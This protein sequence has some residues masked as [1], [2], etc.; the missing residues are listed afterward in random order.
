MCISPRSRSASRQLGHRQRIGLYASQQRRADPSK[1][2]S[3]ASSWRFMGVGFGEAPAGS[4]AWPIYGTQR[5]PLF[6]ITAI[7]GVPADPSQGWIMASD[8]ITLGLTAANTASFNPA[9]FEQLKSSPLG[10]NRGSAAVVAR[11]TVA[12]QA[13]PSPPPGPFSGT[14][15]VDSGVSYAMMAL[16]SGATRPPTIS[17][18]YR[19]Q[20]CT[21]P[22]Y[23][24]MVYL[25]NPNLPLIDQVS[26]GANG[27][28]SASPF[29]AAAPA[30]VNQQHDMA[31]F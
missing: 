7:N 2:C 17:C 31:A 20:D 19:P 6:S 29:A 5:N 24:I 11:P 4:T 9:G 16:D 12:R 3:L 13:P 25:G 30:F 10:F 27:A 18:P 8:G 28:A 26:T 14:V 22:G 21:A 15:L 1:S 23:M